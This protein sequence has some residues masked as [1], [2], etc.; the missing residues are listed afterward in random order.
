MIGFELVYRLGT[1]GMVIGTGIFLWG[2]LSADS[3]HRLFYW[4]LVATS[5]IASVAYVTMSLGIGWVTVGDS[6]VVFV[7]RYVDWILT[8]PLLLTF[9]GLL[10]GCERRTI[11][12][13]ITINMVVM[14]VGT[15]AAL[16]DG[17]ISYGLFAVASVAFVALV[18]MLVGTVSERAEEQTQAVDSLFKSLRN[19]TVILWSVYP[20][21]WLLGPPGLGVLTTT[22]DVMLIVY[23]DLVT[24]V[25]FG[26]I[27]LNAS[28]VLERS[29]EMVEFGPT[30]DVGGTDGTQAGDLSS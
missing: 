25:G 30:G 4:L 7:P 20:L 5:G 9:L 27:S 29:V 26:L 8:T 6:R 11:G 18:A 3:E 24:K 28:S 12:R 22:V 13:L 16:L 2:A 19:L 1:V 10:A 17:P 14:G 15:A 23:L 21:V